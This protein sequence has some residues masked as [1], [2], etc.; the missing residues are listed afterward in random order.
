MSAKKQDVAALY[1]SF[2]GNVLEDIDE[3]KSI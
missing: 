2:L 1:V 3:N